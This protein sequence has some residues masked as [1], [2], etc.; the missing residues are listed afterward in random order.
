MATYTVEPGKLSGTLMVPP[1]KSLAH[2]A[3]LIASLAEGESVIDNIILSDD[4]KATLNAMTALGIQTMVDD[5]RRYIGRKKVRIFGSETLKPVSTT[6]NCHESGSTA[7]FIIPISRLCAKPITV[8]GSG[9]LLERPFALYHDLLTDK[10]VS[11]S[12]NDGKLPMTLKGKLKPGTFRL[13]G[14]VSSQFISGLL[15]VL[16]LLDGDS[17]IEILGPLESAPYVEMTIDMLRNFGIFCIEMLTFTDSQSTDDIEDS[18]ENGIEDSDENGTED[19]D[20]NGTEDGDENGTEYSDENGTEDGDKNGTEKSKNKI[21]AK[22]YVNGNQHYT[23]F[24]Y[25]VEGDWS[26]AAFWIVAGSLGNNIT[27][28]GLRLNTMQGDR[29]ILD[30]MQKMGTHMRIDETQLHIFGGKNTY[31]CNKAFDHDMEEDKPALAMAEGCGAKECKVGGVGLKGI[32]MDVSQCPDLVPALAVA[33]AYANGPSHIVNAAR[34]R[35]KES[36]RLTAIRTQLEILGA[37]VTEKPDGLI[38]SGNGHKESGQLNGG[39]V[40]SCQDHRIVMSCAI[41]A[42]RAASPITIDGVEAVNKSYPGF[43]ED[44]KKLGG[45]FH[46]IDVGK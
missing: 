23:R 10:G 3:L 46:D 12:D 18:D 8:T 20:E 21:G 24:E 29:I 32:T 1:S 2:R 22:I 36:D 42:S 35:I 30:F 43:W 38:L 15:Y 28:D 13:R 27:L 7:R 25:D 34:L 41:A 19:S 17:V 40:S 16:P 45:L 44:F 37:E 11:I 26:Q 31:L 39:R 14:D 9:G 6:I 33:A 5:S 4:I